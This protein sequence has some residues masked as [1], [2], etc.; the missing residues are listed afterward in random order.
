ML[1]SYAIDIDGV[2]VGVAVRLD[3]GFRFVATDL[4]LHELDSTVWPTLADVQRVARGLCRSSGML[5]HGRP[6]SPA[7]SLPIE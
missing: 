6:L 1:Q 3:R 4:R 5:Q 2:F 7:P